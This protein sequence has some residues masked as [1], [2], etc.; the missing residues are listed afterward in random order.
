MNLLTINDLSKG[1]I[2]NMITTALSIKH[3][4]KYAKKCSHALQGKTIALLF[5]KQSTRTRLG[6]EVAMAQ[7]GGNAVYLDY[8]TTHLKKASLYDE[9]KCISSCVDAIAARVYSDAELEQMA[10]YSTKPVI[11]ALSDVH[12]PTQA[13]AD[14]MTIKEVFGHY[15]VKIAYVGDGNN[16]CNSLIQ[17]CTKLGISLAIATPK[18]YEPKI[19]ELKIKLRKGTVTLT[20]NPEHAVKGVDIIYTDTWASMGQEEEKQKRLAAFKGFTVT[21]KL[22]AATNHAKFMHCL[23]AYRGYEVGEGVIEAKN[24]IVFTQAE[25]KMHISKA[26]LLKMIVEG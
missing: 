5:Q 6:F 9:I 24:S 18:G 16:V 13:L 23:P 12:H 22:F 10:A 26:L 2:E 4:T 14:L 8:T 19:K 7:L 17:I 1:Q 25:N 15:N 20:T 3:N 21:K 11:N